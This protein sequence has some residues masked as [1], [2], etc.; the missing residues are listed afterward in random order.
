MFRRSEGSA[1]AQFALISG[2]LL[3]SFTL[4]LAVPGLGF[5]KSQLTAAA[6]AIAER[7]SLADVQ[8]AEFESISESVLSKL[9]L[10]DA[11]F[12]LSARGAV[13]I[14]R[15]ELRSLAGIELQAVSF[16]ISES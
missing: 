1:P 8:E 7:I 12:N 2:P 4:A 16:A 10:A 11:S 14:V 15:V 13:Q 5:Q 6:S 9:G 3:V